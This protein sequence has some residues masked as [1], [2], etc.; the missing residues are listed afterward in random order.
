MIYFIKYNDKRKYG[1][2]QNLS[3]RIQLTSDIR[4]QPVAGDQQA[5]DV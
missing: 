4:H 1:I 2:K 5:K 3:H